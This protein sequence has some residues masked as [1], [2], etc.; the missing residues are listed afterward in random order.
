MKVKLVLDRNM[1]II[2]TNEKGHETFFDT[3]P[4]VGGEDTAASPMEVMLQAMAACSFMDVVSILRKKRRTVGSLIVNIEG[5]RAEEHP[6]VFTKVILKYELTSPDATLKDLERSIELSQDKFCGAAAMF[7]QSGC[8][9]G[10]E[11]TL[12]S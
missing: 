7:R 8:E 6:K 5:E 12:K 11:A 1:R 10:W 3:V 4:K 2:G 9:V